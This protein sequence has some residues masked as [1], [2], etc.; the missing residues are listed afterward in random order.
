MKILEAGQPTIFNQLKQDRWTH[1]YRGLQSRCC[2]GVSLDTTAHYTCLAWTAHRHKN[3]EA[4]DVVENSALG[5][6][7]I[8]S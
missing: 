3:S 6:V 4:S 8:H 1:R 2:R 5:A 7:T